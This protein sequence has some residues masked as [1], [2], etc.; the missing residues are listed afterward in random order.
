[1]RKFLFILGGLAAITLSSCNHNTVFDEYLHT[2][3]EGWEKNDT[4]FFKVDSI[5]QDGEYAQNLG[6]RINNSYPFI[7]LTLVVEQRTSISKQTKKDTVVCS[8][9]DKNGSRK[10]HGTDSYQYNY[11][12][13]TIALRKGDKVTISVRHDMKREI[14]PGISDVGIRIRQNN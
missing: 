10:G 9:V 3:V 2:P 5:P 4:L 6:L 13:S 1:M 11:H 7:S 8:F 12:I 14:L